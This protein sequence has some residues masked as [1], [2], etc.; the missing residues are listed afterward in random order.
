MEVVEVWAVNAVCEK[1]NPK[2][3]GERSE[4]MVLAALLRAGELVAFPFGDNQRYDLL[5]DRGDRILRLQ[6][7][8]GR[9]ARG[10]VEASLCSSYTHRGGGKRG[11]RGQCDYFAIYCPENN[12]VYFVPVGECGETSIY[13]RVEPLTG[14]T[15]QH[16]HVR[17]AC[18]CERLP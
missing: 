4:A 2:A 14:R 13:L 9:L 3:I 1:L 10:V 18:D 8:T 17:W 5:V 16:R 11:Y 15:R 7:K 12:G 6:V